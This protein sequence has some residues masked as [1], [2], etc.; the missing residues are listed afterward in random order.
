M[1]GDL[2]GT[3]RYMSPEQALAKRLVVDHRTDIYSLGATLYELL[4][5][6]PALTGQDREELLRQIALDEPRPPRRLN[7]AIPAELETI[8]L[9]AI[10]KDPTERYDTAKE[11]ADDLRRLLEG[12][13]IRARRHTDPG[14]CLA[15]VSAQSGGRRPLGPVGLLDRCG[16]RG[17]DL[18]RPPPGKA[19]RDGRCRAT[20]SRTAGDSGSR[21]AQG[22]G[23]DAIPGAPSEA[24]AWRMTRQLDW[25]RPALE[26][27]E[28]NAQMNID[29]EDRVRL[30][31]EAI[32]C[33]S[34]LDVRYVATLY[35]HGSGGVTVMDFSPDGSRL[36]S[37]RP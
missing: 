29:P 6:Q 4:T 5:L 7:R 18:C 16:G 1:T 13:P 30:R 36:I 26:A 22:S 9:M 24:R 35:G 14:A 25:S 3:L 2:L 12:R 21:D 31:S 34:Q 28:Q 11:L 17:G 10:A 8:V 32:A 33:A 23:S 37:A 27:L 19:P 20:A 15:V